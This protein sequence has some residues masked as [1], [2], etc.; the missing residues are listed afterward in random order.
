M[1]K[2]YMAGKS[3]NESGFRKPGYLSKNIQDIFKGNNLKET[4]KKAD[5]SVANF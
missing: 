3:Q 2:S 1:H 4:L 5:E